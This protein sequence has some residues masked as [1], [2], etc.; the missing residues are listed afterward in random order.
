MKGSSL[1][2]A[3]LLLLSACSAI[4]ADT[5]GQDNVRFT[6]ELQHYEQVMAQPHTWHQ[7]ERPCLTLA[8][9]A[10]V[11]VTPACPFHSEPAGHSGHPAPLLL[12]PY[13]PTD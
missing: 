8:A 3:T 10:K 12:R 5:H 9:V 11:Q 4:G 1:G 2:V 7:P 13:F 6:H